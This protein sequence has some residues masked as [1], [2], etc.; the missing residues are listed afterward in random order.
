MASPPTERDVKLHEVRPEA[1]EVPANEPA[2]DGPRRGG[3]K[4]RL[5]VVVAVAL[6]L[7]GSGVGAR[8]YL[9]RGEVETD[10]AQ[11]EGDVVALAAR[12]G[13]PVAEL[14]VSDNAHV[15][16]GQPILR[17]DDADYQVRVRQA[18]AEVAIARVQVVAAQAQAGA[19]QAGLTRSEAEE[20]K[21][22]LDLDRAE[23]L[24]QADAIATQSY[25]ATRI[26]SRSAT[27]GAG[28]TRAQYAAA[29]AATELAKA[30]VQ[31]AQA[32]LDL[33][34]LQKS[35]TVLR[36]PTSGTISRLGARVGQLVQPGQN[37]GQLV[38]D[39]TYVVA[40]FKETQTGSL[41]PGQEV[42]VSLDAYPGRTVHGKVESLSGGT[43]SR[44]A[45]LPPDNASGNYVKVVERVPVRIAWS[46][47]PGDLALRAGLSAAV[48]VH[49]R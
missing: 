9:T 18:E 40:N 42:D 35:Y 21:A 31:A 1:V 46:D 37:L 24:H 22:K 8:A 19:A 30:R 43:G 6:L 33:A 27:A 10:D 29:L 5:L 7:A 13:G 47:P 17:L 25:D 32:A 39:G 48:T 14:M 34:K 2:P 28:A 38:P 11:V 20:E 15:V 4:A 23:A 26:Q 12:V 41:H 3:G 45:L 16:A 49:T 44:F 36:A